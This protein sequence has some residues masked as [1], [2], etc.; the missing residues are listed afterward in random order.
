[1][2]QCESISFLRRRPKTYPVVSSIHVRSSTTLLEHVPSWNSRSDWLGWQRLNSHQPPPV[3]ANSR[4]K[5]LVNWGTLHEVRVYGS[6]APTPS[7]LPYPDQ[8]KTKLSRRNITLFVVY[9]NEK[10]LHC[11]HSIWWRV[12]SLVYRHCFTW[13]TY[14][15]YNLFQRTV[16]MGSYCI[17]RQH[18]VLNHILLHVMIQRHV[19]LT[20]IILLFLGFSRKCRTRHL[21]NYSSI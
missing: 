8:H 18:T 17:G 16:R 6:N 12:S 13:A 3:A 4:L 19:V 11:H 7:F 9:E 5:P 15:K 10:F 2:C 14:V 1:V 20:G 21:G